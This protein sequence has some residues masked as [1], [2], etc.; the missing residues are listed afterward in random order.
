MTLV[1]LMP[2]T[3]VTD[4]ELKLPLV[5]ANLSFPEYLISTRLGLSSGT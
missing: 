2:S 3:M 5:I 1:K 4:A